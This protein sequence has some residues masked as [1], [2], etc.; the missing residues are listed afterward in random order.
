MTHI[1]HLVTLTDSPKWRLYK[2]LSFS[3]K[4]GGNCG[5]KNDPKLRKTPVTLFCDLCQRMEK[6]NDEKE[7][8]ERNSSSTKDS[9]SETP[10]LWFVYAEVKW[11]RKRKESR[12]LCGA[13]TKNRGWFFSVYFAVVVWVNI[14][15]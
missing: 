10:N 15:L 2:L 14:R 8:V 6:G 7:G 9:S 4:L 1:H 13:E 3:I 5:T 11:Q 12:H